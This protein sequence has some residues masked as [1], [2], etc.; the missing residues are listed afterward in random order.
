MHND[1]KLSED[2]T[3]YKVYFKDGSFFLIDICDLDAISSHSWQKS[4]SGY[5]VCKTSRKDPGGPK[6]LYL[7][8]LITSAK[9]D[10]DVDHISGE[11]WDNRRS[12]L[13]VCNHQENMFNQKMRSTNS[14]GFYG[15]SYMKKTG[16]YESYIHKNGK[17]HYLGIYETAA[18]A[19][20]A[21]DIAAVKLFGEYAKLNYRHMEAS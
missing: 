5:A 7:H 8:R 12:N 1:Y 20:K 17:K 18:E 10:M 14:T 2:G 13:R 16:K 6:T 11:V 3:C 15:V 9:S 21:R 19:A 4:K